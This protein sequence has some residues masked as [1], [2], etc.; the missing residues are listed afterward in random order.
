MHDKL[1]KKVK[2]ALITLKNMQF[3]GYHGVYPEEKKAGND[4]L[5]DV[6]FQIPL[7]ME[8]KTTELHQTTD[9][10]EVYLLVR[11]VME[12]PSKDLLEDLVESIRYLVLDRFPEC[13]DLVVELKKR[14]P[15]V[16]GLV[17]YVSVR[18]G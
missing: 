2:L 5:V 18:I 10:S 9:Y 8:G 1:E 12:G 6:S 16:G 7:N 14:N 15:P 3:K 13:Q 11:D 4:F 17:D